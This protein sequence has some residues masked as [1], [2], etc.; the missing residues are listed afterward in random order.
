MIYI[1]SNFDAR[2]GFHGAL[3]ASAKQGVRFFDSRF[4]EQKLLV[5]K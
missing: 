2:G 4:E 1:H 3:P 5:L